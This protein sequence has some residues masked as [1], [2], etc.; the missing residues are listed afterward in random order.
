MKPKLSAVKDVVGGKP[1]VMLFVEMP[2]D[3]P[4][5]ANVKD[6]LVGLGYK[7]ISP[8]QYRVICHN[9][10]ELETARNPLKGKVE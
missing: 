9:R 2:G 6:L 1:V 8:S 10:D 4:I 5:P 3:Y 7:M